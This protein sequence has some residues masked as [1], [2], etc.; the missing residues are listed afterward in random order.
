MK[1]RVKIQPG[2]IVFCEWL[3]ACSLDDWAH[4]SE[5]DLTAA[6]VHSA[7]IV[8]SYDR[9]NGLRLALNHDTSND[10]YSCSM[11][12]PYGMIQTLRKIM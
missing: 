7:G 10:N 11:L 3:D 8:I 2:D 5:M 9:K 1:K 6:V 4:E 12:I